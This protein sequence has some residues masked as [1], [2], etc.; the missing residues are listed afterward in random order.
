MDEVGGDEHSAA[1]AVVQ[2]VSERL[3]G[4]FGA[5]DDD[6]QGPCLVRRAA[7]WRRADEA[8]HGLGAP[9]PHRGP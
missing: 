1:S 2:D 4:T 8:G 9:F 7:W 3:H 6:R 5:G